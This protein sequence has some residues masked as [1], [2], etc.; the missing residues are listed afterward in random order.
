MFSNRI[1]QHYKGVQMEDITQEQFNEICEGMDR[2]NH[3]MARQIE[4]AAPT[5]HF[6]KMIL[7]QSD[8][9]CACHISDVYRSCHKGEVCKTC[10]LII[11]AQR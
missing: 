10:G 9:V 1:A 2:V 3:E 5:C 11:A 8:S 7:E 4:E 6:R